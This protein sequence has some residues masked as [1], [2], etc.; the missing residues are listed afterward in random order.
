MKRFA[1]NETIV[2]VLIERAFLQPEDIAFKFSNSSHTVSENLS[3][4]Q[5]LA[6][7]TNLSTQWQAVHGERMLLVLRSNRYFVVA[8]FACLLV[9][10]VPVPTV[11]RRNNLRVRLQAL[12]SDAQP[13]WGITDLDEVAQLGRE[14][15]CGSIPWLNLAK[16]TPIGKSAADALDLCRHVR[17]DSL[18]FLQ[19]TSGS[20]GQPKGV[21]I[22]HRNIMANNFSISQS[23]NHNT[24]SVGLVP[25]PLFHDMGLIG[26]VLQPLYAGFPMEIL[27]PLLAV[28]KPADW[29]RRISTSRVTTSGGPN[30]LFELACKLVKDDDLIEMD[31]SSWKIAFCGA[32]PV[33]HSTI[34]AFIERFGPVGFRR[35]AFFPCYGLAEATLYVTGA[36]LDTSD[37]TIDLDLETNVPCGIPGID[38]IVRIVDLQSGHEAPEGVEGEIWV[39]GPGVAKGYW[40]SPAQTQSVFGAEMSG[41]ADGPFLRTGDLGRI[42]GNMLYVTGRLKDLIIVRGRNFAPHDLECSAE[43]S[44][45]SLVLSGCAAFCIHGR[46]KDLLVIVAEVNRQTLRRPEEWP[47]IKAAVRSAI[48]AAFQ[49]KVDD[50]VLLCPGS[51]PR[52]SSGKVRRN[53]CRTDYLSETLMRVPSES[54][55]EAQW[56]FAPPPR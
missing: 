25:L 53:Q 34:E 13:L 5:L 19:Y 1:A 35:E 46:D 14:L 43:R 47:A 18:A 48:S 10:A 7:A 41:S 20:T 40:N 45:P 28:Q 23:F 39:S 17:P 49:L 29:L 54:V 38:V 6:E 9:G 44:H 26:G 33:R 16:L 51:L 30:F 12:I 21:M 2:H 32:E 52:T 4:G 31:L 15:E 36:A 37:L 11:H 8:F 55:P 42:Q 56:H 50:V 27:N 24:M 22:T 3:Y